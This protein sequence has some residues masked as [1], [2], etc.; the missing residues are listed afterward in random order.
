[1]M[2]KIFSIH[3]H[4]DLA[5]STRIYDIR[6]VIQ[7]LRMPIRA[8]RTRMHIEPGTAPNTPVRRSL[9]TSTTH[10]LMCKPPRPPTP[11]SSDHSVDMS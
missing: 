11:I 6:A 10:S 5:T 9:A 7:M 8:V 1:M 2:T 3:R 4:P